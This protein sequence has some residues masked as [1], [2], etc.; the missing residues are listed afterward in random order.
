MD[1]DNYLLLIAKIIGTI[2]W[3]RIFSLLENLNK[4]LC[5]ILLT[6]K[7]TRRGW[8]PAFINVCYISVLFSVFS[9]FSFEGKASQSSPMS[10]SYYSSL[11]EAL[12]GGALYKSCWRH[13]KWRKSTCTE[14]KKEITNLLKGSMRKCN[15][16]PKFWN[17]NKLFPI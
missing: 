14:L 3:Q 7:F 5:P 16:Y 6:W 4:F 2:M 12:A 1:L 13:I 10:C 9:R 17:K 8:I 15:K 11:G